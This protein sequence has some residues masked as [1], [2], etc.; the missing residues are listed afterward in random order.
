VSE[1][2]KT[3]FPVAVVGPHQLMPHIEIDAAAEGQRLTREISRLEGQV[4][5]LEAQLANESF[6]ARAPANVVEE[7]RKLLAACKETI[8]KLREQLRKLSGPK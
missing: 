1:L 5:S 8:E 2:P 4:A 3:D 7:K 6:V